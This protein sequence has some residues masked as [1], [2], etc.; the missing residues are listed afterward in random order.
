MAGTGGRS[1][2]RTNGIFWRV[3][4]SAALVLALAYVV[5]RFTAETAPVRAQAGDVIAITGDDQTGL[6]KLYLIDTSR[7]VILVYGPGQTQYQFSLL[8]GRY[9]LLD[10]QL[11]ENSE[12]S[13]RANGYSLPE[14]KRN[15]D[16]RN[17]TRRPGGRM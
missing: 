9:Y 2:M 6:H 10:A 12:I 14:I 5:S 7:K 1:L 11:A 3:A 17:A 13:F 15:L 8:A 4:A 16:Q